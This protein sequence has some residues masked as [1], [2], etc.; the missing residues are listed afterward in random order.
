MAHN[1]PTKRIAN[2]DIGFDTARIKTVL[3]LKRPKM[4]EHV[5]AQIVSIVSMELQ[6]KQTCD[7]SGVSVIHYPFYLDFGRELWH[8][9]HET[10]MSGESAAQEAAVL[11][12]KWTARGL[13]QAVLQA[14]R[15]DVFNVAAPVAP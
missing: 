9:T 6:V 7:A 8:I 15:T 3:D 11:I 13:T 14:L 2:W 5:Q 10:E 4:F 1:D 12:T